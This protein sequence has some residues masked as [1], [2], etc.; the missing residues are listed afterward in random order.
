MDGL[1]LIDKPAEMTSHDVVQI[2]R[3]RLKQKAIGHTGTL[4]PLATGLMV[5]VLG[6]A[7]KLS[8]YLVAEDKE[9]ALRVR[10]GRTS[11][12]WDREGTLLSEV[13]CTHLEP[14]TIRHT[15]ERLQGEFEWDV[16]L[17]SAAKVDGRKLC[18]YGRKGEPVQIPRKKMI[19]WKPQIEAFDGTRLDLRLSCSKG[20]FIRAWAHELGRQLGV[21]GLVEGLRRL[22]VGRWKLEEAAPLDSLLCPEDMISR[23]I[24]M[25]QA[26]PGVKSVLA[27]PKEARLVGHGQ[28]PRDVTTRLISEQKEAIQSGKP[29]FVKVVSSTGDLL[30][31]LAAEPKQGLKIRRVFRTIA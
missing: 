7:T 27:G 26:L 14:E 18:E 6:E 29:V 8:D 13:S 25:G 9:Y 11:D 10:L 30:A 19:F 21:G 3:K 16:P 15:V 31:I 12:T 4:D 28:I 1:L 5:L 2:L 22:R 24:P 20:S 23:L 17:F